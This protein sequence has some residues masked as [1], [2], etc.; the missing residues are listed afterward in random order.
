MCIAVNSRLTKSVATLEGG[1][2]AIGVLAAHSAPRA[3]VV[4][5]LQRQLWD[6][7]AHEVK[8]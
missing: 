1:Y 3:G 5:S 2:E 6:N 8:V 7:A 4:S